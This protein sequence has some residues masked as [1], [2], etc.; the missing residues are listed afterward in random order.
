[1]I[2]PPLPHDDVTARTPP[3][4]CPRTGL[5][6]SGA[7]IAD[8]SRASPRTA[9]DTARKKTRRLIEKGVIETLRA[10]VRAIER[11]PA[12]FCGQGNQNGSSWTLGADDVDAM[13]GEGL[14]PSGL[15]EIK[16]AASVGGSA[17]AS[18]AAIGFALRLAVRRI[19][20]LSQGRTASADPRDSGR[21]GTAGLPNSS[22]SPNSGVSKTGLIVWCWQ[23]A[24][25]ADTGRLYGPGL[26][27]L[28]LDPSRLLI[29][30]TARAADTLWALEE[31]LRSRAAILVAGVIGATGLTEARRLSLA[32]E[33]FATPCLLMTGAN[34]PETPAA[35]S[36][37][38]V[39]LVA[40]PA[41][42]TGES[43]KVTAVIERWRSAA[44]LK[45]AH[46]KNDNPPFA[47]EWCDEAHRFRSLADVADRVPNPARKQSVITPRLSR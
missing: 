11:H 39:G 35:A 25:A 1:M 9:P 2:A 32:S 13:L 3:E 47:L 5:A 7:S 15:H 38:R 36:R 12:Q 41:R 4:A 21:D 30:E 23:A 31:A 18:A 40:P 8:R 20:G 24:I 37:W 43:F 46:L 34:Q 6:L 42:R 33:S 28:G 16:P 29:V 14:S 17:P 22:G 27:D 19:V 26:A 44:S 45:A 10:E